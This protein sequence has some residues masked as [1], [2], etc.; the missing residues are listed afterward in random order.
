MLLV[1]VERRV[2]GIVKFGGTR[3]ADVK[4]DMDGA[5]HSLSP[6]LNE[7]SM[8]TSFVKKYTCQMTLYSSQHRG[9]RR[10]RS[11]VMV[12]YAKVIFDI[13]YEIIYSFFI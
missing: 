6:F 3:C 10:Y 9:E 1:Y 11:H 2:R 4:T 8:S 5:D 7:L 13:I 12:I